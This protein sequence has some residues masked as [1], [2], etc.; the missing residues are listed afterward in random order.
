MKSL[1]KF[2]LFPLALFLAAG[3]TQA[4]QHGDHGS[5]PVKVH[6]PFVRMMPPGQPNTAAF[7]T[8]ENTGNTNLAVV[9]AES[10]VSKVVELHTHTMVEGVMQMREIE[11]IEIPAGQRTELKPG[12]LHIMLIGLHKPL[13]EEQVVE[14][15]LVYDDGSRQT[16]EAPVRHPGAEMM[17]SHGHGHHH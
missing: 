11:K 8:L 16:I 4:D 17:Q 6:S 14:I 3:L 2:T 12:G 7:M 9:A 13:S 10:Q 1:L 15:T 5:H